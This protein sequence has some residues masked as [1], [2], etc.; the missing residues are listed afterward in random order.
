[1]FEGCASFDQPIGNW[2]VSSATSLKR[3]FS[4]ATNFNK[5]LAGSSVVNVQG[6]SSSIS[7]SVW[8]VDNVKDFSS[9]FESAAAFNQDI[10]H[11]T[12]SSGTDFVSHVVH[13]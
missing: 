11:W 9:M 5:P 8:S 4:G 3:M 7:T 6:G 1:M 10:S 2:D 12:V 13:C